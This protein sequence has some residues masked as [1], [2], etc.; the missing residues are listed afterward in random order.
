MLVASP[1]AMPALVLASCAEAVKLWTFPD[2]LNI[3]HSPAKPTLNNRPHSHTVTGVQFNHNGTALLTSGDDGLLALQKTDGTLLCTLPA[4][5]APAALPSLTCLA[6]TPGARYVCCGDVSGTVNVWDVKRQAVRWQLTQH[7]DEVTCIDLNSASSTNAAQLLLA[8]GSV[9]SHILTHSLESG[10]VTST[11]QLPSDAPVRCLQFSLHRSSLLAAGGDDGHPYMFDVATSAPLS[12][13]SA[14]HSHTTSLSALLFSPVHPSLLLSASLSSNLAFHDTDS[15]QL[16]QRITTGKGGITAADWSEDGNYI[17]VGLGEGN[18]E[19]YDVRREGERVAE[20]RAHEGEVRSVRWQRTRAGNALRVKDTP[21]SAEGRARGSSTPMSVEAPSATKRASMAYEASSL[22]R[23][24]SDNSYAPIT[25]YVPH[26]KSFHATTV[27]D[28]LAAPVS[29]A[30]SSLTSTSSASASLPAKVR[31]ARAAAAAAAASLPSRSNT[32]DG[33][34]L[35]LPA[36][37]RPPPT[38]PSRDSMDGSSATRRASPVSNRR[39]SYP[40]P[41]PFSSTLLNNSSISTSSSVDNSRRNTLDQPL[42]LT[43]QHATNGTLAHTQPI[44]LTPRPSPATQHATNTVPASLLPAAQ[45]ATSDVSA[46][47]SAVDAL[48]VRRLAELSGGVHEELVSLQIDVFRQFH[49]QSMET[50]ELV[51]Q[52]REDNKELRQ[53]MGRLREEVIAYRAAGA[54]PSWPYE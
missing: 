29:T 15:R 3:H 37:S 32:A 5:S 1:S 42:P 25:P 14:A 45:S 8:S 9:S 19:V 2:S 34:L 27:S 48:L 22:S 26:T 31:A 53:E 38:S 49:Q 16:V 6:V 7:E 10:Q 43:I 23:D 20:W 17:A 51:A 4:A 28:K 46:V 50:A 12:S 24:E 33:E 11:L 52:L 36:H 47:V 41:A 35:P 54:T 13:F 39:S 18:I 30:S 40:A 44:T 21:A